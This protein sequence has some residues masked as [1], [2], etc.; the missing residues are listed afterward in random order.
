[1]VENGSVRRYLPS[2]K[3]AP[4]IASSITLSYLSLFSLPPLI[5]MPFCI[6]GRHCSVAR[7][8]AVHLKAR[9]AIVAVE[10]RAKKKISF[11]VPAMQ[12]HA[13]LHFIREVLR[14]HPEEGG[15]RQAGALWDEDPRD[16]GIERF[17]ESGAIYF[18]FPGKIQVAKFKCSYREKIGVSIN[19]EN[20]RRFFCVIRFKRCGFLAR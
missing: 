20:R 1:M 5:S 10:R 2:P 3:E 15:I 6:L 16:S 7:E 9:K 17:E 4:Y 8:Y 14:I 11:L 18:I 13:F 12:A 19:K